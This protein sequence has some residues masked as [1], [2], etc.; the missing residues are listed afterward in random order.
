[1]ESTLK[2]IRLKDWLITKIGNMAK[3]EN[4]SFTNMVET[5]LISNT[6]IPTTESKELMH[7]L[8]SDAF[9]DVNFEM[10]FIYKQ[11]PKL[12]KMAKE[13]GFTDLAKEMEGN[14]KTE[15]YVRGR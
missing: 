11:A 14:L 12:I 13:Y 8:I 9:E 3:S 5:I 2:S 6:V 7:K 10:E 15:R 1:M 4:R